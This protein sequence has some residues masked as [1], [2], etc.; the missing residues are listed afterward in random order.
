[1][2]ELTSNYLNKFDILPAAVPTG[3]NLYATGA[4]E[5]IG[6]NFKL[7]NLWREIADF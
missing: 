5:G 1:M 3:S 7:E 2:K 4:W 6:R